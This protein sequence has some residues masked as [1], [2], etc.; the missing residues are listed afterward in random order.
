MKQK[1][2]QESELE[3]FAQ[4]ISLKTGDILCLE[5]PLGAGKTTLTRYLVKALG[6]DPDQVH[7]PTFS[8]V[9]EYET[10]RFPI[11]HCDFYRLADNSDLAE[12]G[13]LEFFEENGVFVLEWSDKIAPLLKF[14]HSRIKRVKITLL[15][16]SRDL[17]YLA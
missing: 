17:E 2:T 9:H 10:P 7:S 4:K 8:I 5:G 6:G 16:A 12:M 13:G 3:N 15:D 14:L 1:I 11:F